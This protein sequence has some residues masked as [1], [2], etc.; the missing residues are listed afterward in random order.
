MPIGGEPS[1]EENAALATALK[2]YAKRNGPDDF[3]SLTDFLQSHPSSVWAAATWTGL[4]SEY[5]NTAH[6][7]L[8]LEAWAKGWELSRTNATDARGVVIANRA[9]AELAGLYS[10][11]GQ[12]SELEELLKSVER[13]VLVGPVRQR[14]ADAREALGLMKNR[15]EVAFRCGPLSLLRIKLAADPK[16]PGAKE[17][18][19]SAST[20]QG[21]SLPQVAELS[22]KIGLNYQM[23]FRENEGEFVVPS[24]L[25]WKVGHYAALVRQVGDR[26]LVQDP[27]FRNDVWATRQALE[28]ETS[29]Y[30]LVGPGAL[31]AGWR[32]VDAKEGGAVWGKGVVLAIDPNPITPRDPKKG[33][34]GCRGMM[35]PSVHLSTVNL[36]LADNPIGY[37]PP[38][39]PPVRLTV[40]YNS[41][42]GV[43]PVLPGF[44]PTTLWTCDWFSYITDSPQSG[45]AGVTCYVG[46]GGVRIFRNLGPGTQTFDYEQYDQT[47]LT[48]TSA[49]PISYELLS[50]DGSKLIF[51]QSDGS[52]GSTRRV[53]LSQ[54]VDPQGNALTLSYTTNALGILLLSSITDAIGQ[55]TTLAYGNGGVFDEVGEL[56]ITNVTDPFGRSAKFEYVPIQVACNPCGIDCC[57]IYAPNLYKITDVLGLSSQ[58]GGPDAVVTSLITPYGTNTFI[59]GEQYYTTRWCETVYPDGSRDR[60]EFNT[61]VTNNPSS[62]PPSS[63]PQGMLITNINLFDRDTYYWSRGACALAYSN[64]TK[65]RIYHWLHSENPATASGIL[66]SFKAPLENRVWFD[67]DSEPASVPIFVGRTSLP[68]HVGRVLDDGSTQLYSYGYNGLGNVTNVIDPVGRTF[69]YIYAT[70]GIDLLEMRQTRASNNELL[71]KA[72]YNSQHRPLT[73]TD[74]AGQTTTYTYNAR[75]QLLSLTNARNESITFTYDTNGY[76]LTIDGPLPGTN[77]TVTFTYDSFG[78]RRTLTD[79]SGYT[80]TFEYDN[81][82]R[83][84]RITHPDSTFEQ[85]T[86]DRLDPAVFQDR[87]GRQTLLEHDG[88]REITKVTDSLSRVTSL[89]W[90]RCGAIKSITDPMGRTTSWVTDVQDR[91]IAKHYAD[92]SQVR[93]IYENATSRLRQKVDERQQVTIV[94]YNP[95]NTYHSIHHAN[96]A[97]PT[98]AVVFT[99]DP[100][101]ERVTSITDGVG[102]A[103][104]SYLPI[105]GSPALGAGRLASVAGPLTNETITFGYDELGR[106]VHRAVNGVDSARIY[107]PAGRIMG[108]S[109]VLGS[110]T[111]SYDGASERLLSVTLPNGQTES[112]SYRGPSQDLVPQ[113]ITHSAGSNLLSEFLYTVDVPKHRIATWSQ[114]SGTTPPSLYSFGYDAADQLLSVTVTNAGVQ[115]N[116]FGYS[117]DLA[118]NRLSEQ[119]GPSIY[120]S[121]YNVLNQLSTTTASGPARTNEWDGA[122]R[123]TAVNA[124]SQ[125]AELTYDG[126]GHLVGIRQLVNGTE[127][128]RRLFVWSG[129]RIREERDTNGV[130][131][132]RFFA[133]GVRLETGTNRG[134]YYYTRDHLRSIRELTDATAN[135]RARYAYDPFGRR[136]KVSGD[137]DADFGVAGMFW[138]TEANLSLTHFR[139]Y[140]PGLGRWISR[141]PLRKAELREGP[142]LYAYVANDPVNLTDPS[143]LAGGL[144][145]Y[146]PWALNEMRETLRPAQWANLVAKGES[147]GLD[148]NLLA[149]Q[150]AKEAAAEVTEVASDEIAEI[151][152]ELMD[153]TEGEL[154]E[155][156]EGELEE[157]AGELMDVPVLGPPPGRFKPTR[158]FPGVS[159][160][161]TEF[162]GAGITILTM[163]DCDVVNGIFGLVRQGKGGQLNMFE[164]QMMKEL[165]QLEGW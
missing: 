71:F 57:A 76:L 100:N 69:S 53:H 162:I 130:V 96:T 88:M 63:V 47:L 23:A 127:V 135:V 62:D 45:L 145:S 144:S 146:T 138:S 163:T 132:K 92:G 98:P 15:P 159:G 121:T 120:N 27:T 1:L 152:G 67:Y 9:L 99:Y 13:R 143:G 86:Y 97:V 158:S 134:S 65:A 129:G 115:V 91:R 151:S 29:G 133:Q 52:V 142:N 42:D 104:Y 58:V 25:H 18:Y 89:D 14:V 123:L 82:D 7:S 136:T 161:F 4:G 107:D 66:E 11:L 114:Q 59:I 31:P 36:S 73:I 24:V 33:P 68:A 87:A 153:V 116:T 60:V 2:G 28:A 6:Y 131:I 94:S 140:D 147:E 113:R 61:Y 81:L 5:Y 160:A 108:V 137:L 3:S 165:Q 101:Y 17:V 20:Q 105:T 155:V 19:D 30:F 111:Y 83:I 56:V 102:T 39:G 21:F 46:G 125:R 112:W 139:A 44:G 84:T 74:P 64:Y 38:V 75:G 32:S 154:I 93:F 128:S 85:V 118:G 10:R 149:D 124:G 22:G 54:I 117:Y 34:V 48:R 26:Y 78:R 8:A 43:G 70:N 50:R 79:V 150:G 37:E 51:S 157:A 90:C 109:N 72:T 49:N 40:R 55:V 122:N 77:D 126:R 119:A 103:M 80:L 35:V 141:D 164:D 41:R 148:L 156:S 95:D 110:F 12:M 106:V 16:D